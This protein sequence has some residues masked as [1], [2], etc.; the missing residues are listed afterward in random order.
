MKANNTKFS[1]IYLED[2][3][4]RIESAMNFELEVTY[5]LKIAGNQ[6]YEF[7]GETPVRYDS[8]ST[9]NLSM[10][11]GLGMGELVSYKNTR[12]PSITLEAP[13]F[14]FEVL[15]SDFDAC[16]GTAT[17]IIDRMAP[18]TETYKIN[19]EL[20]PTL[21]VAHNCWKA[22][23]KKYLSNHPIAGEVYAFP[24]ELHNGDPVAVE[25]EFEEKAPRSKGNVVGIFRVKL[26][27]QPGR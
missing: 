24:A 27:H 11:H 16:K 23:C 8:E 2:L 13:N 21:P 26:T 22:T 25:V 5:G 9:G 6:L 4:A 15:F 14:Q 7:K 19:E 3:I 10:L 1:T 18:S 17:M 12:E 20:M